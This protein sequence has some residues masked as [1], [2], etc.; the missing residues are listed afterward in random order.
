MPAGAFEGGIEVVGG[1]PVRVG[2]AEGAAGDLVGE[3]AA[4]A[5]AER[6]CPDEGAAAA[7]RFDRAV[8]GEFAVGLEGGVGVDAELC[9]ERAD[10]WQRVARGELTAG[11]GGADGVGDLEEDGAAV[12]GIEFEVHDCNLVH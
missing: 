1:E 7:A 8:E 3:H 5:G 9:G 6:E 12:G 2:I 10:G 4:F 11:D